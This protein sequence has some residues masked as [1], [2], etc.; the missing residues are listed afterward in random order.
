MTPFQRGLMLGIA[1]GIAL[2]Y[3]YVNTNRGAPGT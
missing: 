1:T 3:A 2:H